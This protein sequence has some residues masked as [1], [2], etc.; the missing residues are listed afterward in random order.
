MKAKELIQILEKEGWR[1]VRQKGS[2]IQLKKDG[3]IELITIP[4]HGKQDVSIGVYNK[5]LK[6]AGLK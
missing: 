1:V 2:H 6:I 5:V 4:D 3:V